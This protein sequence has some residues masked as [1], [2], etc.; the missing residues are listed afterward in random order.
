M[1]AT[2]NLISSQVLGSTATSVTFSSIPSTYT[3]LVVKTSARDSSGGNGFD[4]IYMTFNGTSST[5]GTTFL[6]YNSSGVD[7]FNDASQIYTRVIASVGGTGGEA[8]QFSVSEIYIPNYATSSTKQISIWNA[9]ENSGTGPNSG[10]VI[11][12][13]ATWASGAITSITLLDSASLSYAVGSSF[14]LY[15]I[16]NS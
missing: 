3:D 7:T 1:A 9:T 5:Y 15:G 13:A 8:N 4:N 12:E 11:Q 2:Y 6:R 10:F 14:Y 16:K